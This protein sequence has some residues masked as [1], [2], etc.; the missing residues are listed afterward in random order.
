MSYS[1]FR[2]VKF[3]HS[4]VNAIILDSNKLVLVHVSFSTMETEE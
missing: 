2:E 4:R 1:Y 3:R